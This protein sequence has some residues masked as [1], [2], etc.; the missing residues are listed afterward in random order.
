MTRLDS[1]CPECGQVFSRESKTAYCLDCKPPRLYDIPKQSG[2]PRA[3]GYDS[4]W[5]RLSKKARELQ[6]FCSDC[7]TLDDLTADHTQQAWER[8]EQGKTIRLKDIDVVCRSCN[9]ARGA[10]RGENIPERRYIVDKER[11]SRSEF[12][13]D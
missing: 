2:G 8:K 3:L 5:D 4:K 6:P 7:G 9:S 12:L 11:L 13:E 10:A 1:V